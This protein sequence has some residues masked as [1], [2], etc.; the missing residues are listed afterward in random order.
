LGRAGWRVLWAPDL[1][2]LAF[3]FTVFYALAAF[4]GPRKLFR[5][6]D[7]GWHIRNGESIL[8]TGRLPE[9]D[10][11]SFSRHEETWFAWEWGAD[12]LMGA[13]H[14]WRGLRGVTLLFAAALGACSWLWVRLTWATGGDF[15][16]ACA[17]AS[18]MLSTANLHWLA[19]P[20]VF[21]WIFLLAALLA[22][23]RDW[24][25]FRA[26][27]GLAIVVGSAL[28]ANMHASFFFGPLLTLTY[29]AGSWLRAHLW[30][31][32][33]AVERRRQVWLLW[34][35]AWSAAGT[36]LTPYGWKLHAHVYGYLSDRELLQQ[37]GEFQSFNF[38]VEGASQ[39]LLALAVAA[40]GGVLALGQRRAE[41]FLLAAVVLAMA[42]RSAR[43]L[44]LT[45]LMLLPLANGAI[46]QALTGWQTARPEWRARLDAFFRYS[47]NL[48]RLELGSGG[49][50]WLPLVCLAAYGWLATPA[51]AARTGFPMDQFPVE[52]ASALEELPAEARLLAPDKFGGYL[53]Y[54]FNARRKVFF[55]GR[56]DFYGAAFMR[57][58]I[59]LVQ[60]R[61]GWAQ[62]LDEFRFTH[63]LLPNDYSLVDGL[64]RLGWTVLHRDGTA[65]LLARQAV[66]ARG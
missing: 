32:D 47:G 40:V 51:V 7:T 39:I 17:L 6:A 22:A 60:M 23:E 35:A 30:E 28:W 3:S 63:A 49:Y 66:S 12:I 64:Q 44:P 33:E 41:H 34:A 53:I 1:G 36:L 9:R 10:P 8:A 19:R 54:R 18:P 13:A 26:R 2:V 56:S 46:T 15:L 43:A 58:Y 25:R 37:I 55:D 21:S 48:R 38:H 52:A 5:D 59:R 50:A 57:R 4:D 11:Y 31:T 62:T 65:T 27:H 20:H 42:V 29:A 45:A 24:G 16:I 14:R 61:P